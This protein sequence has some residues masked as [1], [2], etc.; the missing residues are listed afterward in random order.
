MALRASSG[1]YTNVSFCVLSVLL[2]ASRIIDGT[3]QP[4]WRRV[5]DFPMVKGA[6]RHQTHD[7]G[8]GIA[9]AL[10]RHVCVPATV[11]GEKSSSPAS[12]LALTGLSVARNSHRY[13]SRRS[14]S[15]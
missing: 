5:R 8:H 13:M 9:R 1:V 3:M 12:A 15:V 14:S 2:V 7:A 10:M 6:G 11:L 4:V